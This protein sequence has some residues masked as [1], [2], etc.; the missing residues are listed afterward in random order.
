[1]SFIANC[2]SSILIKITGE[3]AK[4]KVPFAARDQIITK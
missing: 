2:Y 3:L 1:M 4:G